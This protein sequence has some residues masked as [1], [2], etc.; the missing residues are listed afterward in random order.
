MIP[1]VL[2]NGRTL[3]HEAILQTIDVFDSRVFQKNAMLHDRGE[4][5]ATVANGGKRPNE[6]SFD[7]NV[8]SNDHRPSNRTPDDLTALSQ[9]NPPADLAFAVDLADELDR[10]STRL[11]SSH[12]TISYAV[13]CLKK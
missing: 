10:K 5:P 3:A 13:F 7:L 2:Y 4:N 6:R 12:I 1:T 8:V 9:A 11:N